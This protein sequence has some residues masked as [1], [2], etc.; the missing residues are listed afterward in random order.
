MKKIKSDYK[1]LPPSVFTAILLTFMV[2]CEKTIDITPPQYDAKVSIQCMLTP[3]SLPKLYLSNSVP[4]FDYKVLS[5]EV[6][7][8]NA[9]VKIVSEAGETDVLKPDSVFN[10][11][12]CRTDY[13]YRGGLKT[14]P[15]TT[16][17]LEVTTK[18]QIFKATT[19][20]ALSKVSIES[21][22]YVQNFT[23]VYGGHEGVVVTIRDVAGQANYYRY[24][25]NRQIDSS[26]EAANNPLKSKCLGRDTAWI[27][28]IGR[29]VYDDT[30]LD[31][32]AIK[33]VME[34]VFSHKKGTKGTIR[35]QTMDATSAAF[36]NNLDN[37]KV[38][39]YN[40][41]VEPVLLKTAIEG[42]IGIFG[43]YVSSEPVSFVYPE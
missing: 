14:K 2:S 30:G 5:K 19:S 23:D 12:Y 20:T 33:M 35:I 27:N 22:S 6:F 36:F 7:I 3:D 9:I 28:E 17:S 1:N 37:Q 21:V 43:A 8:A 15:N 41:F 24:F 40:P 39:I 4:F 34:P 29:T 25:M 42:C 13:F 16:Y 10:A 32:S 26:V 18:G 31:G 11:Y 38:S